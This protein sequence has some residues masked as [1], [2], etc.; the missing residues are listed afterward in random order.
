MRHTLEQ[1][2]A[3]TN[4]ELDSLWASGGF[5]FDESG[6]CGTCLTQH[7]YTCCLCDAS[8][9]EHL[10]EQVKTLLGVDCMVRGEPQIL[11]QHLEELYALRLFYDH[12]YPQPSAAEAENRS[13]FAAQPDLGVETIA[14]PI[15]EKAFERMELD[16]HDSRSNT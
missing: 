10:I 11:R 3:M 6:I 8:E 14:L 16:Y 4:E 9:H 5:P 1:L 7:T 15:N 2:K 12:L 13:G